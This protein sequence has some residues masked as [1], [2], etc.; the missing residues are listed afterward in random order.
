MLY[1]RLIGAIAATY[2]YSFALGKL[3]VLPPL[4]WLPNNFITGLIYNAIGII[5]FLY[6][7]VWPY[8]K[9]IKMRTTGFKKIAAELG[10]VFHD[11]EYQPGQ[12]LLQSPLLSR[13]YRHSFSEA[14]TG[15]Y[16]GVE[17]LLFDHHYSEPSTS[18]RGDDQYF[19]T[20]AVFT[21]PNLHMPEFIMVK[22]SV[23]DRMFESL[24]GSG[25]I[26]FKT[27]AEFSKHYALNGP[28]QDSVKNLFTAELR[29]A[30][31]GSEKRWAAAGVDNQLVLFTDGEYD[32]QL[33]PEEFVNYL[34]RTWKIFSVIRSELKLETK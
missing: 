8:Y 21:A 15:K 9:E 32:E 3:K 26:D 22:K 7:L 5:I 6:I 34:E 10:F 30:L 1:V 31:T 13:G 18:D 27:D 33:K 29:S 28:D 16:E 14:I 12:S 11:G 2:L 23:G 20:V 24:F 4:K 17:I 25:N 19:R